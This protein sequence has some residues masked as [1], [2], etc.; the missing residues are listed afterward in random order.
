MNLG[1]FNNILNNVKENTFIQNFMKEL[2]NYLEKSNNLKQE[3]CL[4]QVVE[5]GT[6]YAYLQNINSKQVSKKDDIPK[7]ILNKIGN[8]TVLRYK[9]GK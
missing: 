3:D 9:D 5:M 6:N 7:E 8:D 2:S 4:Y 1:L